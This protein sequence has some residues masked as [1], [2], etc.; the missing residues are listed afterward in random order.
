MADIS[1]LIVNG[2]SAMSCFQSKHN[3]LEMLLWRD[4]VCI[5]IP[6]ASSMLLS[7]RVLL[8]H[9]GVSS[10]TGAIGGHREG[11]HLE[12]REA[13]PFTLSIFSSMEAEDPLESHLHICLA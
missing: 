11:E 9:A 6:Q 12:V 13:R 7:Q 5:F 4:I 10:L 3:A 1:I 2:Y 8:H